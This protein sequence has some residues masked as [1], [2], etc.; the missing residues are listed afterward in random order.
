MLCPRAV[1]SLAA[2]YPTWAWAKEERRAKKRAER[3][4]EQKEEDGEDEDRMDVDGEEQKEKKRK[5]KEAEMNGDAK[6]GK[7]RHLS[8]PLY[9]SQV[10]TMTLQHEGETEEE[11]KARKKA[12]KA[13]KDWSA[14]KKRHEEFLEWQKQQAQE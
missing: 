11:R 8:I 4:K 3:E 13:A 12:K 1:R 7:V 5:H 2:G 9:A 14:Q 10:F 6:K